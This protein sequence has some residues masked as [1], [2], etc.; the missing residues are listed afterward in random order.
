MTKK[1]NL[2]F[3]AAWLCLV[4]GLFSPCPGQGGSVIAGDLLDQGFAAPPAS[5]RP[6]VYW[7]FMDGNL[8]REGMTADLAAMQAAG[9]GGGIF[10]EV[11]LGLPRGPVKF[12]SPE[13]QDLVVNALHEA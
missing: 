2:L 11:D 7:Y 5:S 6:W 4:F 13:W 3:Q 1:R 8:T 12:M 9:I 10:L